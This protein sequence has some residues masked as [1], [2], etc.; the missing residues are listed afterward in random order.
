VAA[1]TGTTNDKKD[2][3]TIGWTPNLLTAVWVGN[4]DSSPMG[5]VVSGVS[6]ASPIWNK[7]M[8][9][10]LPRLE[11]KDFS[12]PDKIVSLEVDKISGY[13]AHDGFASRTEYFIDGTQA[14]VSDPIHMKL[15]VCKDKTGLAT[16][17]DVANNNYDEKEYFNFKESDL[18]STDGVNRWQAGIDEWISQQPDQDKYKA[19]TDYCRSDGMVNVGIASPSHESTVGNTFDVK[20]TTNSLVKIT[21]VKLWVDGVEKKTWTERPFEMSLTLDNGPHTIKVRAV[22]REGNSQE[23]ESKIGVN[24]AWN[25]SPSPTPTITPTIILTPS[26]TGTI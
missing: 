24:T 26:P 15:K 11:K 25:W 21:E 5:N 22:D 9:Y 7:V 2:N 19:P 4:N 20:I 14:A 23:R 8:K 1:K 13:P 3:W 12:I 16:P 18:V 6:G 10:E 17:D